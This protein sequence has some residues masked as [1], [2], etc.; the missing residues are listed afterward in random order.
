MWNLSGIY[1]SVY[2]L[3]KPKTHLSD[4]RVTATLDEHCAEGVL[5]VEVIFSQVCRGEVEL[6]LNDASGQTGVTTK[7]ERE[8]SSR[9]PAF[10]LGVLKPRASTA[11]SSPFLMSTKSSLSAKR[12]I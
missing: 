8:R 7:T 3:S 10:R 12:A 9:C 2:L 5:E 11:W 1:R 4:V 6:A